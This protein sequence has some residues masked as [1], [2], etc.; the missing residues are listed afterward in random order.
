VTHF[1]EAAQ[2][3]QM[4][5]YKP[6]VTT[7][8]EKRKVKYNLLDSIKE[9]IGDKWTRFKE[10]TRQTFDMICFLSVELGFFYAGSSYLAD[11]H[12]ISDRTIRN[13]FKELEELGQVIKVHRRSKR[14]NGKGKPIY[15][16]VNH[17]Y[18]KYWANLLG[19]NMDEF[20]KDCHTDFH[21]EKAVNPYDS[22][23]KDTKK[24]STYYLPTFKNNDDITKEYF[25][26]N[27]SLQGKKIVNEVLEYTFKEFNR[28]KPSIFAPLKYLLNAYTDNLHKHEQGKSYKLAP[29]KQYKKSHRNLKVDKLP[30]WVT[31]PNYKPSNTLNNQSV[32][33]P[34]I[35][36]GKAKEWLEDYIKGL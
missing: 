29:K 14:C 32:P 10:G 25:I 18:F 9:V 20:N 3:K 24:V 21:T 16:F 23:E 15:L 27:L 34:A 30:K 28:L 35:E 8:L 12:N 4:V 31:D 6:Y 36:P 19:M 17:P 1:V 22:K 26:E 5:S 13:R 11:K 2:F 7:K 33:N